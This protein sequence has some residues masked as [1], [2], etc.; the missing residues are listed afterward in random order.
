MAVILF[1]VARG[2]QAV[3][4]TPVEGASV[5]PRRAAYAVVAGPQDSVAVVD[6]RLGLFLP[7]GGAHPGE[8]PE[9]TV[10]L[11]CLEELARDVRFTGAA[12]EALHHFS[13]DGRHYRMEAAFLDAQFVGGATAGIPVFL[14]QKLDAAAGVRQALEGY[15]KDHPEVRVMSGAFQQIRQAM[16]T[17]KNR[18]AGLA[19]LKVF[20]EEMK[21]S[22][23]VAESLKNS[24][25]S[26][27]AVA[28]AEK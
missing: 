10:R 8:T 7:G 19:Y 4:G 13:V 14:E 26:E 25:L 2:C 28:P 9:Q 17:P 5:T 18:P 27:V 20:V 1:T 12:R 21:A 11:E 22:G 15:A 24:G 23:F 6:T 16:T 3:F